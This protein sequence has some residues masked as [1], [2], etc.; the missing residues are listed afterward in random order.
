MN[1]KE[2]QEDLAKLD[3]AARLLCQ[4]AETIEMANYVIQQA[5]LIASTIDDVETRRLVLK[6]SRNLK[7]SAEGFFNQDQE[8]H[9]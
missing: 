5:R 3:S 4:A 8:H 1:L 2:R 7:A 9:G 6:A